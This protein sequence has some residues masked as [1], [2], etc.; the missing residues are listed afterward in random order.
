MGVPLT[1]PSF[2]NRMGTLVLLFYSS[3]ASFSS[4]F[5]RHKSGEEVI[6]MSDTIVQVKLPDDFLLAENSENNQVGKCCSGKCSCLMG[7]E[8]L[9]AYS[10]VSDVSL[11]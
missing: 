7:E 5:T 10:E 6:A 1:S 9:F 8:E 2:I 4:Q 11:F 3:R